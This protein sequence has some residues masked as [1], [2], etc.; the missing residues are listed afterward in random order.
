MGRKPMRLYYGYMM[1]VSEICGLELTNLFQNLRYI[2]IPDKSLFYYC[3]LVPI[4]D[5]LVLVNFGSSTTLPILG[6]T[7]EHNVGT[8]QWIN[9]YTKIKLSNYTGDT[10]TSTL[11]ME[12]YV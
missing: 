11:H 9:P 7:L 8:L 2:L 10:V 4:V 3:V 1:R 6:G 5:H 12:G